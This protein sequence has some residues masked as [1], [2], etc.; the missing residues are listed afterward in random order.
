[1]S[2]LDENIGFN[3][4]IL[5]K[6]VLQAYKV[7]QEMTMF[8]GM[9]HHLIKEDLFKIDQSSLL[10]Q[11]LLQRNGLIEQEKIVI[12]DT[13]SDEE[14]DIE[15][16]DDQESDDKKLEGEELDNIIFDEDSWDDD[17][18]PTTTLENVQ[19]TMYTGVYDITY[20]LTNF[21]AKRSRKEHLVLVIYSFCTV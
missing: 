15:P 17:V 5:E 20:L 8:V 14:S 7:A 11:Q 13:S 18:G 6:I 1:M 9:N 19:S 2:S 4:D 16:L 12:D 21:Y 3:T 10:T